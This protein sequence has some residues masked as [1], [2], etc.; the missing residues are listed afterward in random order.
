MIFQ[1]LEMNRL[2]IL[3][4]SVVF[5]LICDGLNGQVMQTVKKLEYGV[6]S[7]CQFSM[8]AM[9]EDGEIIASVSEDR[10]MNPASNLKTVT[11]G[12][13][14]YAFGEQY[15]WETQLAYSGKILRNGVLDGDLYIIGGGDPLL[16]SKV[17]GTEPIE[18]VFARWLD[19]LKSAGIT[20]IDGRIVGDGCRLEGMR[21]DPSWQYGDIGTYY[22]TCL[23]ALNFYENKQDFSAVPGKVPGDSVKISPLYPPTPWMKWSFPCTT[24]EEGTGDRLYLYL[25]ENGD[26]GTMRGTLG[27]DRGHKTV[28]CRNNFPEYTLASEFCKYLSTMN[29]IVG[30]GPAA[31]PCQPPSAGPVQSRSDNLTFIGST[32]SMPLAFV[33]THTNKVSDNLCAEIMFRSMG[34]KIWGSSDI[35]PSCKAVTSILKD[36]LKLDVSP[37]RIVI[38]DGSGLSSRNLVSARFMCQYLRAM[39]FSPHAEAFVA[40]LP[41][42]TAREAR[43]KTGSFKGCRTLC[44]YILPLNPNGRRIVFSIMVNNSHL[45]LWNMDRHEKQIV[46]ELVKICREQ[47]DHNAEYH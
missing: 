31:L 33:V 9:W 43:I 3:S 13:A 17:K 27:V 39:L 18:R 36:S 21:E 8:M 45:S 26:T 41:R 44:G 25:A 14:L 30:R 2:G 19:V 47:K 1:K 34:R 24:G 29:V 46:A 15:V 12:A 38:E 7:D 32:P 37:S 28:M 16:G 20:K 4:F 11:T 23:S 22:G 10:K 5:L 42:N 40:S 6:F 35:E